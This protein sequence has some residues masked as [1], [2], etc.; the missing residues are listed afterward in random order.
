MCKYIT[1][2]KSDFNRGI[3]D[4]SNIAKI[5]NVKNN[6]SIVE[7]V[8]QFEFEQDSKIGIDNSRYKKIIQFVNS[9]RINCALVCTDYI[10]GM[11]SPCF[12]KNEKSIYLWTI[13]LKTLI[14]DDKY[15]KFLKGFDY[16]FLFEHLECCRHINKYDKV[17]DSLIKYASERN[18]Y[19]FECC[20]DNEIKEFRSFVKHNKLENEFLNSSVW[21][22][23][24]RRKAIIYNK[25]KNEFYSDYCQSIC[26]KY[27]KIHMIEM[28][29]NAE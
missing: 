13:L 11:I 6:N 23:L 22:N 5:E 26:T 24:E 21:S 7:F 12:T 17:S 15:I 19:I 28:I 18:E 8:N 2:N 9:D 10:V 20:T 25:A 27:N 16:D 3:R 29:E 14:E 4:V 1:I